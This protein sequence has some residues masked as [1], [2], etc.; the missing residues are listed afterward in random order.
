MWLQSAISQ[1]VTEFDSVPVT[2]NGR[3]LLFP[4]AG[5]LNNPQYS[6]IDLTSNGI[7]D[8]YIFDES[9]QRSMTFINQGIHDSV[10]Y[11]YAPQYEYAFPRMYQWAVLADYNHDGYADLFTFNNS[12]MRMYRNDYKKYGYLRFTKITDTIKYGDTNALLINVNA[13]PLFTDIDGNGTLDFMYYT[14]YV[15]LYLNRSIKRYGNADSLD[16]Q[17]ATQC[18]G[19]FS[20]Q[21][22]FNNTVKVNQCSYALAGPENVAGHPYKRINPPPPNPQ[23]NGQSILALDL[24]G[25]GYKDCIIGDIISN[26][27]DALINVANSDTAA[28]MTLPQDSIF[29]G[30]DVPCHLYTLEVPFYIDINNDSLNDLLV[31]PYAANISNDIHS[32]WYYKNTGTKTTPHF[33]YMQNNLFQDNMI[34]VGEGAYPAFLDY[35]ADGLM[36][37]VV[38]NFGYYYPTAPTGFLPNLTLYEN[39]GTPTKPEFKLADT[40]FANIDSLVLQA[41]R[42]NTNNLCPTFGDIDGDGAIDMMIGTQNDSVLFFHNTAAAGNPVH[43]VL[44]KAPFLDS[45]N[46]QLTNDFALDAAPQLV[47]VNNNGK[48]DL[49]IGSLKGKLYYFENTGTPTNPHFTYRTNFFG[50]VN[51]IKPGYF[52]GY[53]IPFMYTYQGKHRLLVGTQDGALYLYDNIDTNLTGTF[54]LMDTL[55]ASAESGDAIWKGIRSAPAMYD[56]NNDSLPD[57]IAGN[58]GGG[59]SYFKGNIPTSL[60]TTKAPVKSTMKL[61]PNPCDKYVTIE[62]PTDYNCTQTVIDVY[63]IAGR[64]ILTKKTSAFMKYFLNVSSLANGLYICRV[65][66]FEKGRLVSVTGGKLVVHH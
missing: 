6:T 57:L 47:D 39:I 38:G 53:S 59:L 50:G 32:T 44:T 60:N 26:N 31:A 27:L 28:D 24:N 58:Y 11:L 10:S 42:L 51:V 65:N 40:N 19:D 1:T 46:I 21:S 8:L 34:D 12:F 35:N 16:L 20:S 48:L 17:F 55:Y 13:F 5:G 56:L 3:Q 52:T 33:H 66:V 4:W 37:L 15:Y 64:K 29:P 18:W 2:A 36:D 7:Q 43:F 54:N 9:S 62:I 45:V 49:I 30:Y 22:T 63:D 25:D 41:H 61:F 14:Y 23:H